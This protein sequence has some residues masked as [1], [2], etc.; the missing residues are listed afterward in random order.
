MP[1][2]NMYC[3]QEGATSVRR[4]EATARRVLAGQEASWHPD[5][6]AKASDA[7]HWLA[8]PPECG[9]SS[10][11]TENANCQSSRWPWHVI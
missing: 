3:L 8:V 5:I 10:G 1:A 4:V 2:S 9:L 6:L 11:C 7:L